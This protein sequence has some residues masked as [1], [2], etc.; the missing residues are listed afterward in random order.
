MSKHHE[1]F[2][3]I[4]RDLF[5]EGYC[6]HLISEFERLTQAGAGADRQKTEGVARHTKDDLQLGLNAG[7]HISLPFQE[8]SAI[9]MFFR[10]LQY[11]YE[12]YTEHFSTLKN[13]R[14]KATH[15]KMQRTDPGGGYHI[16]H[17][18]Q[19]NGD[20]SARVLTYI[21]YL[22]TLGE[23]EGGET[24]FLYQRKRVSPEANM[25]LLWPAAFTHTHRGN[26]VLGENSKYIVTG[27]FY[28]E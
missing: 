6:E 7:V 13:V 23:N 21:L 24:E 19:G 9:D 22:N 11:C 15:M 18:E 26:P 28:Y 20:Q 1:D 17:H 4:Y 14:I 27:W 16:W 2:I 8:N 5:P 25:M 10:G 3:G 12:D